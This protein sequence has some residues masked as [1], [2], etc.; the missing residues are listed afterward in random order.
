MTWLAA[1]APQCFA[2]MLATKMAINAATTVTALLIVF[3]GFISLLWLCV[4]QDVPSVN[5]VALEKIVVV[6]IEMMICCWGPI[7]RA[8]VGALTVLWS[9]NSKEKKTVHLCAFSN[10][11]YVGAPLSGYPA[12]MWSFSSLYMLS[13]VTTQVS[14][15]RPR[16]GACLTSST[17]DH[18]WC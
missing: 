3:F 16:M 8:G 4:L 6:W 9:L 15:G 5:L 12:W 11:H 2:V 14:K 13:T 18:A 1:N 10:A 7:C 17:L